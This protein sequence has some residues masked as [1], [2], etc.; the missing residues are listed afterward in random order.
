M[1]W[2]PEITP[3]EAGFDAER[4]RRIDEHFATYVETGKLPGWLVLVARRGRIAHLS[5][6]GYRDLETRAAVDHDTLFRIYSMTKP[7]TSVAAMMLYEQGALELTD[8]VSKFIPS[9]ADLR[10]Y[11]GGT[12]RKVETRPASEPMLIWH[13][14]THT[15]GLSYG[16]H[17]LHP[18]DEMYRDAGF[19]FGTPPALDLEGCCDVW[20]SLPLL[21]DPGHAWNYSVSTDVLGR[22]VEV[23]SGQPLDEFFQTRILDPLDMHDTSFRPNTPQTDRLATLY[24]A[25]DTGRAKLPN[26]PLA[27]VAEPPKALSGGGGL[28]STAHDYHRFTQMLLGGGQLDGARLLSNRTLNF[29]TRNHLPGNADLDEVALGAWSEVSN[30]GKGFGLGFA[31]VR[32]PAAA[33]VISTPG[34]LSWGG[35]AST[36]FWV[37]PAEELSVL[38]LTQLMPSSTHPIRTQLHQ[39]V[40]QALVD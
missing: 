28:V 8:P 2:E 35:L 38:F 39:L 16:F 33:K 14:L 4:L 27:T 18:V 1:S 19:E 23:A 37:D 36:A 7:L 40:Y 12:A 3:S 17:H 31:V 34:E 22:V 25:D 26:G 6:H 32:D 10:V 29:M 13:L 24:V 5:T 11:T 15:S 21:F 9:F 30:A 20:A